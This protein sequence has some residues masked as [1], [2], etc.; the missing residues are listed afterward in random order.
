MKPRGPYKR[1]PIGERF[2]PKVDQRGA[3]ECWYWRGATMGGGY[4]HIRVDRGRTV[5][6]HRLAY[7]LLVGPIPLGFTLDHFRLNPGPRLAPCSRACVNPTHVEPVTNL[8]NTMRGNSLFAAKARQTVCLR[9][10][11]AWV[12]NKKGR[13]ACR[14]CHAAYQ[15]EHYGPGKKSAAR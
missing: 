14:I 13:R 2:W 3:D 12:I 1:R 6:A 5:P 10:H 9:G 11:E 15:R 8:E 4:G 7:E